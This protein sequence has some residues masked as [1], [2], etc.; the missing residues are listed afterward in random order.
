MIVLHTTKMVFRA[1]WYLKCPVLSMWAVGYSTGPRYPANQRIPSKL[2]IIFCYNQYWLFQ[3]SE[4]LLYIHVSMNNNVGGSF[5]DWLEWRDAVDLEIRNDWSSY[6]TTA[7]GKIP[8]FLL[9][10]LSYSNVFARSFDWML[11]WW[12]RV[13]KVR[14]HCWGNWRGITMWC[15]CCYQ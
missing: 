1:G 6:L 14:V 7:W 3:L 4:T 8:Y 15:R 12:R 5:I 2:P 13:V 11:V 9:R 10:I